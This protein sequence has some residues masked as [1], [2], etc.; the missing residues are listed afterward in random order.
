ML[1][2][3]AIYIYAV[4]LVCSAL[5]RD[6]YINIALQMNSN[7]V[8][9]PFVFPS[10]PL[11]KSNLLDDNVAKIIGTTLF[12]VGIFLNL[13]TLKVLGIKGMYNGDSFGYLFDAPVTLFFIFFSL[14]NEYGRSLTVH[15]NICLILRYQSPSFFLYSKYTSS[16]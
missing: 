5:L 16:M 7:T 10:E 3:F 15:T 8:L 11:A 13:W 12:V 1:G 2:K 6:H 9:A 4:Y 14:T